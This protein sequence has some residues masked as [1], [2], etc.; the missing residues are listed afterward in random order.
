MKIINIE[1]YP[2][3]TSFACPTIFEFNDTKGNHYYFRVRH[4]YWRL[5]DE[6]VDEII[7]S[8]DASILDIDGC[9]TW[10]EARMLCASEKIFIMD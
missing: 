3:Q 1:N 5:H 9:C 10:D 8:G 2:D 4:G 7:A 6:T